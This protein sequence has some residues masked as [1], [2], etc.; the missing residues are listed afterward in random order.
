MK[1]DSVWVSTVDMDHTLVQLM[2]TDRTDP[3]WKAIK[4]ART[5]SSDSLPMKA[6]ADLP[7]ETLER[8]PCLFSGPSGTIFTDQIAAPLLLFNLGQ[9]L[10]L[11]I[12]IFLADRKTEIH[13]DRGYHTM[14]RC[15][16]FEALAPEQSPEL[17]PNP[18][19]KAPKNWSLPKPT[20]D[21]DIAV[22]ARALD[23]PAIWHDP[24]IIRGFFFRGDV[25]AALESAGVSRPWRLFRC[26]VV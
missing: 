23:G 13:S 22:H 11:P 4:E 7:Q 19:D 2:S 10:V 8:L 5:P 12:R 6:W 17:K 25:V 14:P 9:T 15:E 26:R 1:S 3:V 18:Y 16:V 24:Q 20:K 21:G